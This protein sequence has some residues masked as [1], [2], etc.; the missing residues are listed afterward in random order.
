MESIKLTLIF[1]GG[2]LIILALADWYTQSYKYQSWQKLDGKVTSA[3]MLEDSQGRVYLI[4]PFWH[5][6]IRYTYSFENKKYSGEYKEH[7]NLE[8][9]RIE[10]TIA[11]LQK[12]P[13]IEVL[14]NPKNPTESMPTMFIDRYSWTRILMAIGGLL[15]IAGAFLINFK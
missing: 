12:N 11:A 14:I 9:E 7:P 4:V 15:F 2:V 10:Q 1:I 3:K 13:S 5:P 8:K 6:E